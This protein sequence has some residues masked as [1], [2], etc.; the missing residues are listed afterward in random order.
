MNWPVILASKNG[1]FEIVQYLVESGADISSRN[2]LAV[3]SA[4]RNKHMKIIE[5]LEKVR[6]EIK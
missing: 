3:K 5:Y 6:K 4:Q 1:Y 2:Y